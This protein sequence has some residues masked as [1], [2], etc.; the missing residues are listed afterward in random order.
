MSFTDHAT[1]PPRR[2]AGADPHCCHS[3]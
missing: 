3:L 1:A 2:I